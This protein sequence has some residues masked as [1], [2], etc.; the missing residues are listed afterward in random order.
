MRGETVDYQTSDVRLALCLETYFPF[1]AGHVARG[2]FGAP[3]RCGRND[4]RGAAVRY[5]LSVIR[6]PLSAGEWQV[7]RLQSGMAKTPS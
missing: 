4:R 7:I 3:L 2:D 5:P 6:C 1:A